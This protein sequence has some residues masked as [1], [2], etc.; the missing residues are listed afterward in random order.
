MK[1]LY[2]EGESIVSKR[3]VIAFKFIILAHHIL[4]LMYRSYIMYNVL[5]C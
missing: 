5:G 3:Q 4:A 2:P 1:S